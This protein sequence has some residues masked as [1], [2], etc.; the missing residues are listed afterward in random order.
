VIIDVNLRKFIKFHKNK[1]S[2]ATLAVHPNNHPHD[3]DLM[4]VD[5]DNRIVAIHSKP[6]EESKYYQNLGNA[7]LYLFSPKILKFIPQNEF[8]DFGKNVF[9]SAFKE[10]K[11]YGHNTAEYIRD[12]G[13]LERLAEVERDLR[14]GKIR[15]LNSENKQKAIFLDRDGVINEEI[16]LLHKLDDFKLLP[17]VINA[18]K[19]INN[20]EYLTIVVTNQPVIARNLCTLEE[21][22]EIHKKME[23]VIGIEGAKIDKIYFCPHHPDRG[24]PGENVKYKT[25]CSCRKPKT[26]M[27]E[28]AIKDYNI[29]VSRSYIIGDSWR[30]IEC[31]KRIGLKTIK[32]KTNHIQFDK[33]GEEDFSFNNLFEAVEFILKTKEGK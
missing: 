17:N 27:I 5:S 4:E 25:E 13:T 26:G 28:R 2:E 6:H 10:L 33:K 30:D 16:N 32:T 8:S 7:C 12:M 15:R 14:S 1:K 31:G 18:I 23:T 9:P 29:D 19:G 21:L 11:M 20:S 3:S 22:N 24:Y